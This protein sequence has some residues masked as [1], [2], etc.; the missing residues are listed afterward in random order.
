[1][2]Q[3]KNMEELTRE[4]QAILLALEQA[5]K[6]ATGDLGTDLSSL[7]PAT[8]AMVREYT[9]VL[10]LLAYD[11]EPQTPSLRTKVRIL[12]AIAGQAPAAS[13]APSP[14]SAGGD[15]SFDEMTIRASVNAQRAP[16]T[17]PQ[18]FAPQSSPAFHAQE[19]AP[20][21]M[22]LR[23]ASV[24]TGVVSPPQALQPLPQ[25]RNNNTSLWAMAA[26]LAAC[27]LGLGYFAGQVG[28]RDATIERLQAQ[29][30]ALPAQDAELANLREELGTIKRRFHMVTRVARAAYPMH[31]M[32]TEGT[33]DEVGKLY[34]CGAHQR[35]YLNLETL[36]PPP[37]GKIYYL[38]FMTTDG[39]VSG[40]QVQVNDNATAEM[41]S[42]TM[43]AGT[44]GFT[45]T[46]E[47]AG[48]EPQ[49]PAGAMVLLG[50]EKISL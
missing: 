31:M 4:D 38:W 47:D 17:G 49:E 9:E 30:R 41:D 33:E 42:L 10:G 22:T 15:R 1:M 16:E 19:P 40:G 28:A 44:H 34:V 13:T 37:D 3:K 45:V 35:W 32:G 36:A 46:L 43:P 14:P 20:A 26:M 5:S 23:H 48:V 6:A 7:D 12:G 27:L 11:L 25:A 29:T 39:P 2:E 18:A 50:E 21:E 8:E 24:S